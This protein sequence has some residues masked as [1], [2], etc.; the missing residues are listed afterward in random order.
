MIMKAKIVLFVIF[1]ILTL[2]LSGCYRYSKEETPEYFRSQERDPLL[3]GKW[4]RFNPET[5]ELY[6]DHIIEYKANGE[7]I[8][9]NF[10]DPGRKF[11]Y[12][13]YTKDGAIF[14]LLMGDGCKIGRNIHKELYRFE[15]N[16]TLLYTG[17]DV[18]GE[19]EFYP[20]KRL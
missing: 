13:Y 12:Y 2:S 7:C 6:G 20:L 14:S 11:K 3:I 1:S 17:G 9:S 16:N 18:T 15:K 10:S 5:Q 19:Y 8:I 4:R